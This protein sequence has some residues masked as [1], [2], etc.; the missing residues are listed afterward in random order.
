MMMYYNLV[1]IRRVRDGEE[2]EGELGWVGV[3]EGRWEEG[4]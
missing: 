3:R 4:K 2:G 1:G